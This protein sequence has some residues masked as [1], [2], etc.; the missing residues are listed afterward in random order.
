MGV[1]EVGGQRKLRHRKDLSMVFHVWESAVGGGGRGGRRFTP[2]LLLQ[3]K[4]LGI[5]L[6]GYVPQLRGD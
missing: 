4:D 6:S 5:T 2:F 1:D 3:C